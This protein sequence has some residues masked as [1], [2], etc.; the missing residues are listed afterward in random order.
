MYADEYANEHLQDL[1]V[2]L[3]PRGGGG[4]GGGGIS[5]RQPQSGWAH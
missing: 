3:I 5:M 2:P 4:T 1:W